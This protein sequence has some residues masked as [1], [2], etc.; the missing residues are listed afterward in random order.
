MEGKVHIVRYT[1]EELTKLK[2]SEGTQSDWSAAAAM[3]PV[4]IEANIAADP[5]E[6]GMAMDWDNVSVTLPVL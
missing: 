4:Q 1:V 2:A 3:T 6:E 5:D